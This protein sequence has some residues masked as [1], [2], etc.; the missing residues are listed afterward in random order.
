MPYA[1]LVVLGLAGLAASWRLPAARWWSFTLLALLA[2]QSVFFV[3]SRYRL[4]L[5]PA[6]ALL[7]GLA[8]AR[9]LALDRVSLR[10][11]R[12]PVAAAVALLLVIPWGLGGIRRDWRALAA[13]NEA[14]RWAD[15]GVCRAGAMCILRHR[16]FWLVTTSP[17]VNLASLARASP[18]R[19]G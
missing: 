9:L 15:V 4:A 3:V 12:W 18:I 5:V 10:R 1:L 13:A 8:A 11:Q 14:L 19:A 16:R 7:A 17:A 2:V 6:L